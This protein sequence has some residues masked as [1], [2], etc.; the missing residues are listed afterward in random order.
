MSK[1]AENVEKDLDKKSPKQKAVSKHPAWDDWIEN[2]QPASEHDDKIEYMSSTQ[3]LDDLNRIC[4]DEYYNQ[5]DLYLALK[6]QNFKRLQPNPMG[7]NLWMVK[8][9]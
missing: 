7:V 8:I 6:E 1:A 5:K 9:V 4:D 2:H 3:I